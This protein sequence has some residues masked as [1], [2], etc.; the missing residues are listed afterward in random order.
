MKQLVT[1]TLSFLLIFTGISFAQS[2]M[3]ISAADGF[4]NEIIEADTLGDGSQA[5]DVYRLTTV[6]RTY[7]F[8]GPIVSKSDIQIIGV[9]DASTGRPPCI[10]P[11][12]LADFTIPTTFLIISGAGANVRLEHLYLLAYATDNTVHGDGVAISVTADDVRLT[13]ENNVF[14]G[15]QTFGIGYNGNWCDFFINDNTFRNFV[16]PNQH[17]LGE[18][19]RNTWP[20][21]A[22]TDT[23]VMKRNTM[24]CVNGYA[25]APVTKYYETYFEFS[26][27]TVLYT[28][29]NPFFIFNVTDAKINNNIFYG[30]YAGG[31]DQAENPWWDNLWFPDSSYGVIALQPLDSANAAIFAP[32]HVGKEDLIE[33]ADAKRTVEVNGN[34]YFWPQALKDSWTSW[35][36]TQE[37][38]IITADFMN[39]RTITMF[40]DNTKWPGLSDA[41]NVNVDPGFMT[42][43]D[44]DI[45]NGS[46]V[47][48]SI[49]LLKYFEQVRSGTASV[50]YW[51]YAYTTVGEEANWVPTWPLPESQYVTSLEDE[52]SKLNTPRQ[53]ALKQNYPNP[54]NP[55]TNIEFS[56]DKA[57]QVN[58]EIYNI[59]G[60][61]VKTVLHNSYKQSGTH[62]VVIDMAGFS[63]GVYYYR[64]ISKTNT[65]TKKMTLIK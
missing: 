57:Q 60:Q 4:L 65:V 49:G 30:T 54:F 10:Q 28:F 50:D 52:V 31:V 62:H 48:G 22:Y 35:N 20:G 36:N 64:L 1:S 17:Y 41:N 8:N 6:N 16:H 51:G 13:V 7:T 53:F 32:E 42:A 34:S 37:N 63:S 33:L 43:L 55:A 19:I 18:V 12:V 59:S 9:P 14:D 26:D 3:D 15:W 25:A 2:T 39:E 5:H 27:N 44:D 21:E 23:L 40:G 38:K 56:L 11:A 45:L 46:D 29:K 58:L 61:L 24:L 47:D